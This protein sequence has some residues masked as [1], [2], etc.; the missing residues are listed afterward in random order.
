MNKKRD[1]SSITLDEAKELVKYLFKSSDDDIIDFN[2]ISGSPGIEIETVINRGTYENVY[3]GLSNEDITIFIQDDM[4]SDT[5]VTIPFKL[6]KY[7][8]E[9]F[10]INY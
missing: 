8:E 9:H 5:L 7:L 10:N 6:F 2:F 4:D 1:I 3:I